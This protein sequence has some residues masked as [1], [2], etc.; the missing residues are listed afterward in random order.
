MKWGSVKSDPKQIGTRGMARLS[1]KEWLL[2][3]VSLIVH[4]LALLSSCRHCRSEKQRANVKR[5]GFSQRATNLSLRSF[6][7]VL[8]LIAATL[9]QNVNADGQAVSA[10]KMTL[11]L[12]SKT[13]NP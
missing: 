4:L 12:K 7:Q 9:K 8:S 5:I 3:F 6:L 1:G 2:S 13:L 10:N 11:S